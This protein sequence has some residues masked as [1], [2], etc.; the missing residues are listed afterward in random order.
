K[1]YG[2]WGMQVDFEDVHISDKDALSEFYRQAAAAL[3]KE[4]FKI[5]I[6]VVHRTEESAGPNTYTK[7]MMENWR[8]GYDLKVLGEVGDFV[9]IMSYGQHTRRT[10]PGPSQGLPWLEQVVQYFLKFVPPEKLSLG[11]TCGASHYFTI[12]DT[13]RYYQ[14]A[15]SWSRGVSLKE[16]ESLLEQYDAHPLI[17]DDRQIVSF[18]Y[19]ER[20]GLFEWLF[21]DN[22][23]RSFEAKLE[24]VKKY[25]LRGINSWF[26]GREIP[27]AWDRIRDF[28]RE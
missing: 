15:R 26:S 22:D 16:V 1:Q 2:L 28:K 25:K 8:G 21:I 19:F 27:E 3:H 17:W 6:A 4:G 14:N 13:A 9:K 5:S 23:I 10:T 12:A 18:T 11:I 7:W 24:L 20:G